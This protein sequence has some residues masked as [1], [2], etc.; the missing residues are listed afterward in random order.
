M[1]IKVERLLKFIEKEAK[2]NPDILKYELVINSGTETDHVIDFGT[3]SLRRTFFFDESSRRLAP[4]VKHI[5]NI[6]RREK[7]TSQ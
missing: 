7:C 5:K 6:R 1:K 3:N 4:D 2:T